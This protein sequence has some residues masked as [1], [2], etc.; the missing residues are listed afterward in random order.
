MTVDGEA[1]MSRCTSMR[2]TDHGYVHCHKKPGHEGA[3]EAMGSQDA[4]QF[5]ETWHDDEM[6][7]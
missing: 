2:Q 3:H 4:V 6:E 7:S 1:L 5:I